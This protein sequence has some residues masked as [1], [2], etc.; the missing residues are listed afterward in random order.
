V[1]HTDK[2]DQGVLRVADNRLPPGASVK[3]ACWSGLTGLLAS[4]T[5]DDVV[6]ALRQLDQM[7]GDPRSDRAVR[8]QL[9]D[10]ARQEVVEAIRPLLASTNREI[11]LAAIVRRDRTI[12]LWATKP[13][14]GW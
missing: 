12:R 4:G 6:Y 7:S 10:F 9:A 14:T 2:E 3:T 11:C 1:N 13:C 8:A 5:T